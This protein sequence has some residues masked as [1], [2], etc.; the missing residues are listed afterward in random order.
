MLAG[1]ELL[2]KEGSTPCAKPDT[3]FYFHD[4]QRVATSN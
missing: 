4:G 3:Y 2:L 1:G